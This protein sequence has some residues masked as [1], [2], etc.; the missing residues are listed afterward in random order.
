MNDSPS[1]SLTPDDFKN[2][3]ILKDGLFLVLAL[4][5]PE[6]AVV[7]KIA[8]EDNSK[9]Q[10]E[11]D[12]ICSLKE[13]Y[14]HLERWM[15]DFLGE[16]IIQGG[17]L[18]GHL[19]YLQNFI[20]GPT[21]SQWLQQQTPA[22]GNEDI[23]ATTRGVVSKL[24]DHVEDH[25]PIDSGRGW[26]D[27]MIHAALTRIL[28]I[29]LVGD[30]A[31]L[32]DV[33]VNGHVRRGLRNSIESVIDSPRF[34]TTIREN[35]AISELGHWNFHG[36]NIILNP[37]LDDGFA[38]I[39]PDVSLNECDPIFGLAR[40]LYTFPH[41]AAEQVAYLI[42]SDLLMPKGDTIDS[43]FDVSFIWPEQ[44]LEN[45]R[46]LYRG[47]FDGKLPQI[48]SLDQRFSSDPSLWYRLEISLLLCLLRGV[49]IN[50]R[51]H[52]PLNY[53]DMVHYQNEAVFLL[54]NAIELADMI[55]A[56]HDA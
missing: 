5:R 9:V 19:F 49:G 27:G 6:G 39:D 33:T 29:P 40:L 43:R 35:Q 1:L 18:E 42:N 13:R 51:T 28:E 11:V 14:S 4:E 56:G 32:P 50:Y 52:Y 25:T 48:H 12:R 26:F 45:Y 22:N 38:I 44:T 23:L 34:N 2:H 24:L 46:Y 10:R 15:P 7:C 8:K 54:L 17:V 55:V 30:I 21:L 47:I 37:D 16:G 31:R 53:G 20:S 3:R 36:E 41:D